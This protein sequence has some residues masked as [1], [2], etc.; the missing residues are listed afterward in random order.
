[1]EK[2]ILAF[3]VLSAALAACCLN[4][5]TAST[6]CLDCSVGYLLYKSKICLSSCPTGYSLISDT[7]QIG[8]ASKTLFN[9][10]FSLYT[11]LSQISIDS[12]FTSE[13][14]KMSSPSMK[15]LS[16]TLD[17]GLYCNP[18]SALTSSNNWTPGPDT[19]FE[20]WIYEI[21][22]GIVFEVMNG[23]SPTIRIR[24]NSLQYSITF[25]T[26]DQ[27]LNSVYTTYTEHVKSIV[28]W[29]YV[30]IQTTQDT[31]T[32][33]IV[34]ISINGDEYQLTHNNVEFKATNPS[35][36]V[37]GSLSLG[38]SFEGFIYSF[39]VDLE[40]ISSDI[41]VVSPPACSVNYYFSGSSCASCPGT[42]LKVPNCISS[43]S[44]SIC[45]SCEYCSGYGLSD[46]YCDGT[47][48]CQSSCISCA[49][50]FYICDSCSL[51]YT[52]T[53]GICKID[54]VPSKIYQVFTGDFSGYYGNFRTGDDGLRYYFG[55]SP[56]SLD[57]VPV[58][59]R[60]LY[61]NSGKYLIYDISLTLQSSFSI[62]LW[63]KP[64]SGGVLNKGPEL[65]YDLNT[66]KIQYL[67]GMN[68]YYYTSSSSS[69]TLWGYISFIVNTQGSDIIFTHYFNNELISSN[70]YYSSY[71]TDTSGS[72]LILGKSSTANYNG[73]IYSISIWNSA[74]TNFA[75]EYYDEPCGVSLINS[76]L[77]ECPIN[78]YFYRDCETCSH[79]CGTGCVDSRT[80]CTICKQYLC[81]LCTSFDSTTCLECVNNASG[82]PCI[83]ND[84]Y[85]EYSYGC[86]LCYE[87]CK[88]CTNGGHKCTECKNPYLYTDG[89]C[90]EVCPSGY[91]LSSNV[92]SLT[93]ESV[94]SLDL[95]TTLSLGTIDDFKIGSD[96][97]NYYPIYDANDPWPAVERGYY[98]HS[99]AYI[100]KDLII[101]PYLSLNLWVK[102]VS[103]GII[104]SKSGVLELTALS[105]TQAKL[106]ITLMQGSLLEN[107]ITFTSSHW[108]Y[109]GYSLSLYSSN[110]YSR[111]QSYANLASQSVIDVLGF[112]SD[113]SSNPIY[114]GS[115]T[116][117]FQ[118][119]IAVINIYST[120]THASSDYA[121][122]C[123][124]CNLCSYCLSESGILE[125]PFDDS[126]C[127][128]DC[129]NGCNRE[130]CVLCADELCII[131]SDRVSNSCS[132][133]AANSLGS[134]C[135]CEQEYYQNLS[136]C[137][138]C[139][140][141]CLECDASGFMCQVCKSPWVLQE[142]LCLTQC[143]SGFT[144]SM[145]ICSLT[146][147]LVLD[148]DFRDYIVLGSLGNV[149]IGNNEE[150]LYPDFDPHDP[151]PNK[152]RG[153][154]FHSTAY[155]T[156]N[157]ALSPKFTLCFWV[158]PVSDGIFFNKLSINNQI[159]LSFNSGQVA[160]HLKI[161]SEEA[162]IITIYTVGE[163]I[164][165]SVILNS[166]SSHSD[167]Q[168]YLGNIADTQ[169]VINEFLDNQ[170]G[171]IEIGYSNDRNGFQGFLWMLQVYNQPNTDFPLSSFL[172]LSSCLLY[173]YPPN[174]L[175]CPSSCTKGCNDNYCNQCPDKLC[176]RCQSYTSICN[177]CSDHSSLT[178]DVCQCDF[179]YF[180]DDNVCKEC[181]SN[182]KACGGANMDNCLECFDNLSLI[183][184]KLCGKC[185]IGY[186]LINNTCL[187]TSNLFFSLNLN[188][189]IS[190]QIKDSA[191]G[192]EVLTGTTAKFYPYY[193]PT[194]P[195]SAFLR[196]F[197]FNG[198]SS[199]LK[200]SEKFILPYTFKLSLWINS[201]NPSGVLIQKSGFLMYL[202]D[203]YL[204]IKLNLT[205]SII[206]YQSPTPI[207]INNWHRIFLTLD[208]SGNT[209]TLSHIATTT[210]EGYFIDY[211]PGAFIGKGDLEFF[212]GFIYKLIIGVIQESRSLIECLDVCEECLED[213]YC[214]PNCPI[215]SYWV[216]PHYN[217]C[218]E[219]PNLCGNGCR[220]N[221][222]CSL[223]NDEKCLDCDNLENQSNCNSCAEG[224]Q[225]NGICECLPLYT[226]DPFRLRCFICESDQF[227]DNYDCVDCPNLCTKCESLVNCTEC[228]EY[229]H[230]SN[231]LCECDAGY[232]GEEICERHYLNITFTVTEEN[233]IL[234]ALSEALWEDLTTAD[235]DV[236]CN[237]ADTWNL[238]KWSDIQYRITM[239]Y[240]ED[241]GKGEIAVVL[242]INTAKVLSKTNG[243]PET[244]T[245]SIELNEINQEDKAL[246]D[247]AKKL[248][249][250]VTTAVTSAI[251]A[252]SLMNP[253]PACLWSF[254]NTIQMI[255]FIVLATVPIPPKSK[256]L[257]IGLKNYNMFPNS[258]SYFMTKG[259]PHNFN[260]AYDLGYASDSV[261]IN[262]GSA[263]TAFAF[264]IA[265]WVVLIFLRFLIRKGCCSKKW[266][267]DLIAELVADYKYG[268]FIRY[269][270][271]NY[272]EF[273]VAAL[274]GIINWRS[275]TEYSIA[276]TV[277]SSV[278]LF[279]I[280][281]T[282]ILC[283][284]M[285]MK[286]KKKVESVQE[287]FD[288]IY[289]TLFYEFNNDKG[290]MTSN[291]YVFF[292]AKRAI[293]GVILLFLRGYGVIQMTL[294]LIICF[295]FLIY[296]L[297]FR[298]F[299][300]KLLNFSNIFT[301][302]A[303]L[304]IFSLIAWLLFDLSN[305]SRNRLDDVIYYTVYVIMGL[306]MGVSLALMG[307]SIKEKIA[308]WRKKKMQSKIISALSIENE[309]KVLNPNSNDVSRAEWV[310]V[311]KKDNSQT[312]G[313]KKFGK[314]FEE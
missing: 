19:T 274:I 250:T 47:I 301:E 209:S 60:G 198:T 30:K 176:Y 146:S 79:S 211:S 279:L 225:L 195:V 62:G 177:E 99:S 27:I 57:P 206:M 204:Y 253:N 100:V 148:L 8:S 113:T 247:Q 26:T 40:L 10:D 119:F 6:T 12:F 90:L 268:F 193:E 124:D 178:N 21:S 237:L 290:V 275:V 234:F 282:P 58:D 158:M 115:S 239:T 139:F 34:K 89:L 66:F 230:L 227:I 132:Q 203:T 244:Y 156:Y 84:M 14:Q 197:Y 134:P 52:N 171:I 229:S 173:E 184:N 231:S 101:S 74:I 221:E 303:T 306:Q 153:Y 28:S 63:I 258:F 150:N 314:F 81:R 5:N 49:S 267:V 293:Y 277:L 109:L 235:I 166:Q 2:L 45:A 106:Q 111:L 313:S 61:F 122:A 92:C 118:G 240:T 67:Y 17:R 15:T 86:Y 207:R 69:F 218:T 65:S 51:G 22:S 11:D 103:P 31:A 219:C 110:V 170:D 163:W 215:D 18:Y 104:L 311:L 238:E 281:L 200:V 262:I 292:F 272:L 77:I 108:V 78:S 102:V 252:A 123:T 285:V 210:S 287:E 220:N 87:R 294:I 107:T 141:R 180:N 129:L 205:E 1:M 283:F 37:L 85:Y 216:G 54:T 297:Y 25:K 312:I 121:F 48:C 53:G 136:A 191:S 246:M 4:C 183:E 97:T 286:R 55:D 181:Y 223:C 251:T 265:L 289:G 278:I 76:C 214:I 208:F 196:G 257:I 24:A 71:F 190:G 162:N 186:T 172:P 174:C 64:I 269:G 70:T 305:I 254:I 143:S 266:Y 245:Y 75:Y 212:Y 192:I 179:H 295:S 13:N 241:P 159:S 233:D 236:E 164:Y 270:I 116:L 72:S 224:T 199:Y 202:Q 130:I 273:E 135:E 271:T 50:S 248:G 299:G 105:S 114:I 260:S 304:F 39:R 263:I 38:S 98:F 125:D 82:E 155:V 201:L 117:S 68:Y 138:L 152:N 16:P 187:L 149:L 222:S 20:I 56:E 93:A 73:F 151:W 280:P 133:C 256:G 43:S 9:L 126:P 188:N 213:G 296:L 309:E 249:Q 35:N 182:C 228:L 120:N 23:D 33:V 131:C 142:E 194:D 302:I 7:C 288:S 137:Y 300:E 42:C 310:E 160:F 80:T 88:K 91:I 32:S 242:F 175:A 255:V 147:E 307:K 59:K 167:I 226:W 189:T 308:E 3:S 83:C 276:N 112:I 94:L 29:D 217:N 41:P 46:C 96:W 128:V 232:N 169:G 284:V 185:G 291:F 127:P 168:S 145:N 44:C 261:I 259:K 36:W 140:D 157:L 165:Y 144:L 154:F 298:P 264:F 243:T 95:R 161:G